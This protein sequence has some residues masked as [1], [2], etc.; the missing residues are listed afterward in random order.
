[1]TIKE[2]ITEIIN[3]QL[4][5]GDDAICTNAE[6]IELEMP[7]TLRDLDGAATFDELVVFAA[8]DLYIPTHS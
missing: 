4:A 5:S 1:M 3:R 8:H 7:R 6:A 2:S